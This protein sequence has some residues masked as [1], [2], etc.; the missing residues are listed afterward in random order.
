MDESPVGAM[1]R[2]IIESYEDGLI[3]G[4][5]LCARKLLAIHIAYDRALRD[6][7][8]KI[9]TYLHAAIEASRTTIKRVPDVPGEAHHDLDT[10]GRPLKAG[11]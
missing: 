8:A 6:T 7:N 5:D 10:F 2:S 9:P 3:A 4:T 1:V 11:T